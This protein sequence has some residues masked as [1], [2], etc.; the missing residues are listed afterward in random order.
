MLC[1]VLLLHQPG[2]EDRD[3]SIASLSWSLELRQCFTSSETICF[4][5]YDS[6]L[7]VLGL[8][9]VLRESL[10]MVQGP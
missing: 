8:R 3:V 5:Y 7:M 2:L 10:G 6:E 9:K 4:T 1:L